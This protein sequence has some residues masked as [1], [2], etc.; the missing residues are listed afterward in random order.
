MISHKGC[1]PAYCRLLTDTTISAR[2]PWSVACLILHSGTSNAL[3]AALV[4]HSSTKVVPMGW[5][6]FHGYDYSGAVQRRLS[7]DQPVRVM[8]RASPDGGNGVNR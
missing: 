2:C 8:N 1:P 4:S 3:K 6:R 7:A 5:A